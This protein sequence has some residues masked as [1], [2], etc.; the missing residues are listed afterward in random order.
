VSGHGPGADRT[1]VLTLTPNPSLDLLFSAERLVW[2]D[3]NRLSDPRRRAGGQGMNVTR[4]ALALGARSEAIA[5]LGG[6]TGR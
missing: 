3:A 5:L 1:L 4:A 6:R 2:D